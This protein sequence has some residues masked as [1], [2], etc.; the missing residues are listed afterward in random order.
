LGKRPKSPTSAHGPAAESVDPAEAT[1]PG[2]R[3]GVRRLA[4]LLL[5]RLD[6]R[7]AAAAQ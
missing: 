5:E 7:A 2:D 6:Q 1:R 4:D 3:L